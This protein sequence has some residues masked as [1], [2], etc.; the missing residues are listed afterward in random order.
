MMYEIY[1]RHFR[2]LPSQG[3]PQWIQ[4]DFNGPVRVQSVHIQFQGGFTGKDCYI[5]GTSEDNT[6]KLVD[7]YP[8][9]INSNQ[10]IIGEYL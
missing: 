8:D 4:L 1:H 3:T 7:F 6:E 2:R 5:E 9:D 10:V